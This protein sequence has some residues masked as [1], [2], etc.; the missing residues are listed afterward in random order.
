VLPCTSLVGATQ[1]AER[2]RL[3]VERFP[4]PLRAPTVSSGI[5]TATSEHVGAL[6]C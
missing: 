6:G 2:I 3:A 5:A 4:W 1:L